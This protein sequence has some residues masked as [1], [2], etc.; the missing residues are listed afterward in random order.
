MKNEPGRRLRRCD[1]PRVSM[2]VYPLTPVGKTFPEPSTV[3]VIE[4]RGLPAG[5][6]R[7]LPAESNTEPWQAQ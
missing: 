3:S 4:G 7:T 1:M 2:G 6:R 5:P